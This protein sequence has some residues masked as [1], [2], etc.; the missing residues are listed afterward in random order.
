[1]DDERKPPPDDAS[2]LDFLLWQQHDVIARRQALDFL[3]EKAMRHLVASG[4]WRRPYR[5]VYLATNGQVTTAQRRWIAVLATRGILAGF[6]ALEALGLRG[7]RKPRIQ[8]LVPE[9]RRVRNPPEFVEVRR[10]GQLDP[11]DVH[12]NGTPPA[13]WHARSVV[14]AAQWARNDEEACLVI[15]ASF[16]QRLVAHDDVHLAVARMRGVIRERVIRQAADDARS[17]AESVSEIDFARLCRR[18]G[19]P[20]PTRQAIRTDA[21]GRKRYRDVLYE[22]YGVHVEIDGGQHMQ[23]RAWT[24]DMRQHNEIVI[25]GMRLLRFTTWMIRHRPDETIAQLRAALIAG[26]WRP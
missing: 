23:V 10:T 20:E 9:H 1:M 5:S 8:I 14:D 2:D 18:Y 26:G 15:A 7:Y 6:S 12:R 21:Q 16:Q 17:G 13:T 4:R 11:V 24:N 19:L 22:E 25:S 3:T